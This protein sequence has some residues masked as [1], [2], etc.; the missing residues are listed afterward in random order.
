MNNLAAHLNTSTATEMYLTIL[1]LADIGGQN[2]VYHINLSS[3]VLLRSHKMFCIVYYGIAA[4]I[5][6]WSPVIDMRVIS[7]SS[8]LQHFSSSNG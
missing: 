1:E 6:K 4:M 8:E 3:L 5:P 2:V 7:L